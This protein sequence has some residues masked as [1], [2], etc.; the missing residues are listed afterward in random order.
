MK[1]NEVLKDLVTLKL[2]VTAAAVTAT[3]VG[4]VKPFGID[5]TEQT[6]TITAAL[7]LLGVLASLVSK[8]RK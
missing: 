4:L 7:S 5:L 2:P 3:L 6:V 1:L 8:Y